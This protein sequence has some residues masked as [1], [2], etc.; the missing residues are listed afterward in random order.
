MGFG[1]FSLYADSNL[2][3]SQLPKKLSEMTKQIQVIRDKIPTLDSQDKDFSLWLTDECLILE[4]LRNNI[5]YD[6]QHLQTPEAQ[7]LITRQQ[8]EFNYLISAV[9][10]EITFF[11]NIQSKLDFS[12]KVNV[13][14]FGAKGDGEHDD[15]PAIYQAI[16]NAIANK[17]HVVFIPKGQYRIKTAQS[18]DIEYSE[19]Q[20]SGTIKKS[21]QYKAH[22]PLIGLKNFTLQGEEGTELIMGQYE[23]G[24]GIIN[25]DNVT[26]KNIAIN[27]CPLP[28]SQGR[29][30]KILDN[31]T[32]DV[33]I[34]KGYPS[35]ALFPFKKSAAFVGVS[36]FFSED[37]I[38]GTKIPLASESSPWQ[39][40]ASVTKIDENLYRF[41]IG[42]NFPRSTAVFTIGERIVSCARR[43]G[44]PAVLI[45]KSNRCTADGMTIYASPTFAFMTE[46]S[47]FTTIKNS[48]TERKAGSN[49]LLSTC[50][51]GIMIHGD[52]LGP[53][54]KNCTLQYLGDDF[55]NIHS[56]GQPIL[57]ATKSDEIEVKKSPFFKIGDTVGIL[58]VKNGKEQIKEEATIIDI[59]SI[60][61]EGKKRMV[62]KLNRPLRDEINITNIPSQGVNKPDRLINMTTLSHGFVIRDNKFMHGVSRMLIG[63]HNGTLKNNLFIDNLTHHELL[64]LTRNTWGHQIWFPSNVEISGNEFQ[65]SYAKYFIKVNSKPRK[66]FLPGLRAIRHIFISGNK[67]FNYKNFRGYPSISIQNVERAVISGNQ[68]VP[69]SVLTTRHSTKHFSEKAIEIKMSI[70]INVEKNKIES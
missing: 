10:E 23:T 27:Y 62:I 49:T 66:N 55:I 34:D 41:V 48:K 51:D 37:N 8:N 15:G 9:E 39:N 28:I 31:K 20:L 58:E 7:T 61:P 1:F 50:A 56:I 64:D 52:R 32:F 25:C 19:K 54:I 17:V 16:K 30:V 14:D 42:K 6:H 5:K 29:I 45:S 38:S 43:L 65:V 2:W 44:N 18:R 11:K 53:Y 21:R 3:A 69:G 47:R 40:H 46:L 13:R 63:G 35:P 59:I 70:D 57:K 33:K 4:R 12:K 26:V 68:F 60:F 22:I 24:I 67:F 36:R